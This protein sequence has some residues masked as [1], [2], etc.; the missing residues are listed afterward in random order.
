MAVVDEEY[1]GFLYWF[2]GNR[3]WFDRNT[4]RYAHILEVQ[5]LP[6]FRGQGV[7]RALLNHAL[8]R[9]GEGSVEAVY[10]DTTDGNEVARRLYE[11]AGFNP[12]LRTIHYIRETE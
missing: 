11:N 9:L 5:V 10:I 7:G 2:L 8:D 6:R 12:F 4:A 3:P 1:A